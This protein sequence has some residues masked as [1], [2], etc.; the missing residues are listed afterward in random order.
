MTIQGVWCRNINIGTNNFLNLGQILIA[1]QIIKYFT[2][3][4][5]QKFM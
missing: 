1:Q 2:M 5:G 3:N 4:C